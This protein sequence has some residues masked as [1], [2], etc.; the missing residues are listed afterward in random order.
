MYY[1]IDLR[2]K[3]KNK[4]N[5]DSIVSAEI[6]TPIFDRR[7]FM[8][9]FEHRVLALIRMCVEDEFSQLFYK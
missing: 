1:Q 3:R 9:Y 4:Y 7:D 6:T 2:M 5:D 8:K